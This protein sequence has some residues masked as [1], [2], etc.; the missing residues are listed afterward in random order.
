MKLT[1]KILLVFLILLVLLITAYKIVFNSIVELVPSG[2]DKKADYI[3][4][5]LPLTETPIEAIEIK[6]RFIVEFIKDDSVLAAINGPDNLVNNYIAVEREGNKILIRSKI[7]LTKYY[8]P[9][10]IRFNMKF[11]RTIV[12]SN[13]AVASME[14]FDGDL[15]N[16]TLE[17]STVFNAASSKIVQTNITGRETSTAIISKTKNASVRLSDESNLLLTIDGG[18]VS[19]TIDEKADFGLEGNVKKNSIIKVKEETNKGE[20]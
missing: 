8:H 3:Y 2:T 6:G 17:D 18:E 10:S 11:L 4:R 7:D 5:I 14:K 13:G 20:K 1:N 16:I 15:L 19:G 9:I 12:L